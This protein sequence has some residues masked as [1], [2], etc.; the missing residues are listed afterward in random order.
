AFLRTLVEQVKPK[1]VI[2]V[3]AFAE[4][5]A[6]QTLADYSDITFGRILHPSPAS[7]LA[8]KDWPGTA[9]RQLQELG[10]WE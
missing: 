5:R 10:I 2:G 1:Y 4:K 6:M 7:P 8:N 9:T 3:G